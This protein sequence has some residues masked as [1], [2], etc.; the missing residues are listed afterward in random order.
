MKRSQF[1]ALAAGAA[2]V[3]V[4]AACGGSGSG[5]AAA[6]GAAVEG[7]VEPRAISWLLS[8]PANGAVIEMGRT[9][10]VFRLVAPRRTRKNV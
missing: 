10:I 8:R 2:T 1:L 5:G 4:L 6:T 7:E 3:P 9:R